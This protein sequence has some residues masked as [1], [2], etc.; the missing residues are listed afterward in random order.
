MG[1]T[2]GAG[3]LRRRDFTTSHKGAE[4]ERDQV[5]RIATKLPRGISEAELD[6]LIK[7]QAGFPPVLVILI[8]LFAF[9]IGLM[10]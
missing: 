5:E 1:G 4:E 6:A 2:G 9:L 8:A 7:A 3:G 10:F